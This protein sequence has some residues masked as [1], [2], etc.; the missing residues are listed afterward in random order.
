M[1]LPERKAWSEY[2]VCRVDFCFKIP[3]KMN[4]HDA[5]ALTVDGMVAY[6]LLFPMGNLS[7][8]KAV[9]LHSTPGGL[10]YMFS[11]SFCYSFIYCYSSYRARW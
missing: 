2:V 5:V 10:V 7:T 6:S 3:E 1:A 9:L 4:Y 8:G 11:L